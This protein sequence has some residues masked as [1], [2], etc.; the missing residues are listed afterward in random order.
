[1][2]DTK[3][4]SAIEVGQII[5]TFLV[6]LG[7]AGE[8]IGTFMARPVQARLDAKRELEIARLRKDAAEAD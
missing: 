2:D 8:F 4:L 5:S 6:V 7:V 3:L 1:M